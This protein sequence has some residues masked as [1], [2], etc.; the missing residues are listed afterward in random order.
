MARGKVVLTAGAFDILHPGHFRLLEKAKEIGGRNS[1]LVVVVAR[2]ETVRRNKGRE[3]IFDEKLRR[4]MVSMI[5]PVD[6]VILGYRPFSFE[7]VIKRVKPDIVV[8]GYDQ[9]RL[10]EEF[11]RFCREKGIDVKIVKLR[12]YRFSGPDSSSNVIERVLR[13][14]KNSRRRRS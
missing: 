4:Y 13:V 6:E 14:V 12:R 11:R 2:D 1:K 10:M 8:F 5:K 9:E 7:K 3:P